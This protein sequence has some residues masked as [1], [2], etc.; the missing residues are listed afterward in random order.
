MIKPILRRI[1]TDRQRRRLRA[2]MAAGDLNRLAEFYGTDKFGVHRYT[3]HYMRHFRHLKH[4]PIKLIE[5]GIGGWDAEKGWSDPHKG[6]NSL[7]MWKAYF[8][9]AQIYGIDIHD[10]RPH[11]EHRI[12]TFRGSQVDAAF[13]EAVIRETG[14]PDIIIDDGSHFNHHQIETFKLLFPKLAPNGIYAVEDLF[15]SYWESTEYYDWNGSP[16]PKA[17]HT[18]M[19]FF[20]SLADGLNFVERLDYEPNYFDRHIT[21]VH[22]YHNLCFIEKGVNDEPTSLASRTE[23]VNREN[24]KK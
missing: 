18:A 17:E 11:D 3:P 1:L 12:K 21:G 24:P 13:L 10:K 19:N 23:T 15:S 9:K 7:R 6:G 14:A 5:I 22:F 16:D 4:Q 8:P 20:K 2:L